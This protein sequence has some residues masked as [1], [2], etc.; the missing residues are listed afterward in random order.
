MKRWKESEKK[1]AEA[2]GVKRMIRLNFGDSAPDTSPHPHFSIEVKSRK[3]VSQFILDGLKQAKDYYP[4]KWPVLVVDPAYKKDQ[5]VMMNMKDFQEMLE[6]LQGSGSDS[7][8]DGVLEIVQQ[9]N[10]KFKVVLK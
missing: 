10:G 6:Q 9:D 8:L 4:E 2:F 1:A 5:I 3:K 7:S